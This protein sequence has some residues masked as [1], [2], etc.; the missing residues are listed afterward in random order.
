MPT[1]LQMAAQVK[2]L[3]THPAFGLAEY[4]EALQRF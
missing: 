2:W 3:N 1:V 4:F